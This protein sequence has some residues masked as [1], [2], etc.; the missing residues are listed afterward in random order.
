MTVAVAA[1][2]GNQATVNQGQNSGEGGDSHD[3]AN[4]NQ[5]GSSDTLTINLYTLQSEGITPNAAHVAAGTATLLIVL[6]LAFNLGLRFA[7]SAINKR[8][9]GDGHTR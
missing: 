3:V 9:T 2:N 5:K 1:G 6:L 8:I 4:I 7:A